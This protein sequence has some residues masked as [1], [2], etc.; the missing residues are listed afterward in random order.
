M[1]MWS[2]AFDS[3]NALDRE[4]ASMSTDQLLKLAEIKALLS[5]AQELSGIRH[6]GINP[7]YDVGTR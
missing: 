2:D 3:M 4:H 6:G 1:D 7:Q 5:I